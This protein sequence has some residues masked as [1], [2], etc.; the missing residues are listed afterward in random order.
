MHLLTIKIPG[1]MPPVPEGMLKNGRIISLF[2]HIN[3]SVI[4]I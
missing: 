4:T 1:H 3:V 2:L